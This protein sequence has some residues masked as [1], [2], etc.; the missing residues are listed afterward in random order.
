MK[1][2]PTKRSS[3]GKGD[4]R[5]PFNYDQYNKNY[6]EIDW[7]PNLLKEIVNYKEI[8]WSPKEK[9]CNCGLVINKENLKNLPHL[10]IIYEGGEIEHKN[11]NFN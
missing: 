8:D 10:Y 2:K 7:S 5:R 3:A 9:C 1:E 6:E 4:K 11:C